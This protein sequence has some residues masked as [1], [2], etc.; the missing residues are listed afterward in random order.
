MGGAD[1][2]KLVLIIDLIVGMHLCQLHISHHV[3]GAERAE[4]DVVA[5]HAD[6]A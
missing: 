3:A 2:I 5:P 4:L 6:V 1:Q